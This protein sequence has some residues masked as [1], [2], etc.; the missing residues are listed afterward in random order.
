MEH[1]RYVEV[2][3][4]GQVL[5]LI[6]LAASFLGCR[7]EPS[8]QVEAPGL[9]VPPHFPP[10]ALPEDNEPTPRRI[11]LGRRLFYDGR[12][13]RTGE[14][15]CGTCH[16]QAHAFSDPNRVSVGVDGRTGT[17]NSMALVNLA[18]TTSFFWH[19]GASSLEAQ[20]VAPIRSPLEMDTTIADVIT[21]LSQ[22]P[23]LAFQF[24]EAYAEGPSESTITRALASFVRSLISGDSAYDRYLQGETSAMSEAALRGEALFNSERAECFHCHVGFNFTNNAFRNNGIEA[25]DPDEGRKEITLKDSDIGKFRVPTL[26][27]VAVSAPYMHDGSL[28][29]LDEV[30]DAYDKGGRGHVNT[31]PTIQPLGLTTAEKSDL[32]SFLEALTDYTFLENSDFSD[33]SR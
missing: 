31:D 24:E 30:I 9:S 14:I 19:G 22:E 4:P 27:N 20:A 15:S 23:D 3:K 29:T 32:R 12:L 21:R 6:L 16:K 2:A 11:A 7:A 18:W 17:R 26:R 33:P 28:A 25:D 13:S 1:S 10:A 5:Q 8:D